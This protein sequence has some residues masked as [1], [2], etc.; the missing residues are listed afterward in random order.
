MIAKKLIILLAAMTMMAALLFPAVAY[1]VEEPTDPTETIETAEIAETTE[2]TETADKVDISIY[3]DTVEIDVPDILGMIGES[4]IPVDPRPFTPDGQATVVD[5]AFEGDGKK[6]YTFT[7]PAGNVF[8][9]VIDHQR[10][11]DNVYFL[12]AVTEFDL[13]ALA[14]EAANSGSVGVSAIPTLPQPPDPDAY[15]ENPDAPGADNDIPPIQGGGN[16]GVIIFTIVGALAVGGVG[17]YFKIVRPKQQGGIYEDDEALDEN[18]DGE[19]MVFE[20]EPP[21]HDDRDG[22]DYGDDYGEEDSD[23]DED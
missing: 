4:A 23:E 20:D 8:Y 10:N 5:L 2:A 16:T 22:D 12:N 17:Y 1:A 6:F 9:L 14:E 15:D 19:E 7:T 21:E 18:D 3:V 13:L 11:T